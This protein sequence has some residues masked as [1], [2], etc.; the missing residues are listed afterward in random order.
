MS[1]APFY[2]DKARSGFGYGHHQ[3]LDSIL[4]DGLT[5]AQYHCHM[6][7]CGDE[8]AKKFDITREQ[9]DDFAI[10]SYKKAAE[11][12]KVYYILIIDGCI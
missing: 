8:T 7:V 2:L 10:S 11:A 6:G 9:Q 5:D 1:N 4:K 3:V 12:V